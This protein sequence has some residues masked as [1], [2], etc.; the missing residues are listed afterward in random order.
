MDGLRSCIFPA[1]R[2]LQ[3]TN[4]EDACGESFITS[5]LEEEEDNLLDDSDSSFAATADG[6]VPSVAER[7]IESMVTSGVSQRLESLSFQDDTA[8]SSV[9]VKIAAVD[10]T[11]LNI[12]TGVVTTDLAT[13]RALSVTIP[14]MTFQND[15]QNLNTLLDGTTVGSTTEARIGTL[16]S[17]I[18]V[19]AMS[20]ADA[21]SNNMGVGERSIAGLLVGDSDTSLYKS[22]GWISW[23]IESIG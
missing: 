20:L 21:V 23:I 19:G 4:L 8:R 6:G 7:I 17:A 22:V 13:L 5:R 14:G 9:C 18:G 1:L 3:I 15:I 10:A 16:S 2:H 11:L 12:P